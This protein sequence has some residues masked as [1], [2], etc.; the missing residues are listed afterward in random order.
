MRLLHG[1]FRALADLHHGDHRADGDDHAQGAQGRSH[2]VPP[3][4]V[5][6][7]DERS[8]KQRRQGAASRQGR[9][10]CGSRRGGWLRRGTASRRSAVAGATACRRVRQRRRGRSELRHAVGIA[11]SR[12]PLPNRAVAPPARWRRHGV[13][14]VVD[15]PVGDVDRARGKRRHVGI[16]R[17]QDDGDPFG[18]EL[19]E[20]PQD[21]DAGVRIEVAGRLVGQDQRGPVHQRPGD[22]HALLLSARHLRRLVMRPG[23][24]VPRDPAGPWPVRRASF[25]GGG[26][27]SNPTA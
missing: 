14:V 23:R 12:E 18:V 7:R 10:C 6:G 1:G 5:H 25:G 2:L 22:G 24:P 21:L 27:A 13:S 19:L 3:Q 20:H 26:A 8:R 17:H 9:R 15:L 11:V 16:V 4:G